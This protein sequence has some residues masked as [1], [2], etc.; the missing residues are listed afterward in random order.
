M[1]FQLN[2]PEGKAI[3]AKALRGDFAHPGEYEILEMASVDLTQNAEWQSKD[4]FE[5]SVGF[6]KAFS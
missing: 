2:S 6:R 1:K 5:S 4:S 3:L